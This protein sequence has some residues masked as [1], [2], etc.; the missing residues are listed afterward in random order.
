MRKMRSPSA[1]W[2]AAALLATVLLVSSATACGNSD[3]GGSAADDGKLT[4]GFSQVGAESGWRTANT[5]SIKDSAA[6]AASS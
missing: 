1:P 6:A 5:I 3:T 4:L 2:R